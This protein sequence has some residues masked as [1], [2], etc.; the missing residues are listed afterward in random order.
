MSDQAQS[1][2]SHLF[3]LRVWLQDVD[4]E[5]QEWRGRIHH[6]ESG[7]TR[8]FRDWS[9]LIPVL[10][11]MLR[12]AETPAVTSSPAAPAPDGGDTP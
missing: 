11:T 8:Y 7:Q 2:P 12:Q 6:V 10:L 3:T 4:E 1:H 5:T 9:A